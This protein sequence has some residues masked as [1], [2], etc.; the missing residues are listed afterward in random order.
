LEEC[1]DDTERRVRDAL[2]AAASRNDDLALRRVWSRLAE[3]MPGPYRGRVRWSFLIAVGGIGAAMVTAAWFLRPLLFEAPHRWPSTVAAGTSSTLPPAPTRPVAQPE[4][5]AQ[6]LP[7]VVTDLTPVLLG[8][9]DVR[10]GAKRGQVVRLKSGARVSLRSRSFLHVDAGQRPFLF[11]GQAGLEV[12]K[13]P[14]G[15]TFSV[16]AGPYVVVVVGTKFGLGVSSRVVKVEVR[17]GV[18][19]VWRGDHMIQ[20]SAGDSWK[21]PVRQRRFDGGGRPARRP[22]V[23]RATMDGAA[24]HRALGGSEEHPQDRYQEA[25]AAFERGDSTTGLAS[26]QAAA[27]GTGPAAENAGLE[28]GKVLRDRMYQP[29][30]AIVVWRRYCDRFPNGLLRHEVDVSIIETWLM[31]GER[32]AARSEIELFLRRHPHSERFAEMKQMLAKIEAERASAR[33]ND[34]RGEGPSASRSR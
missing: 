4:P 3:L 10:T 27:E 5:K 33:E 14:P 2:D 12:P 18:V 13:Q 28:L 1:R 19:Q 25:H 22:R 29:R 34:T 21:G 32:E 11:K 17:E 7:P 9:T 31:V 16:A 20:L 26:L 24:A 30:Q 6:P 8:P 15:E 23:A